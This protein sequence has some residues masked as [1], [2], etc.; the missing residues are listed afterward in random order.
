MC[1]RIKAIRSSE[2]FQSC[3]GCNFTYMP[4]S[5]ETKAACPKCDKQMFDPEIDSDELY[6]QNEQLRNEGLL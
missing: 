4:L 6:L 5:E 2:H 3:R 1:K